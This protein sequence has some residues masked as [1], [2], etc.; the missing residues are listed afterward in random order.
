[1]NSLQRDAGLADV[2]ALREG[3]SSC[4]A[5]APCCYCKDQHAVVAPHKL[6]VPI[7]LTQHHEAIAKTSH[8]GLLA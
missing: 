6:I 2:C 3:L 7:E 1:M 4:R 8:I 5:G